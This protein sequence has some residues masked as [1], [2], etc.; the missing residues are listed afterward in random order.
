MIFDG[1]GEPGS[2]NERRFCACWGKV[3]PARDLL[4]DSAAAESASFLHLESSLHPFQSD[5]L[6]LQPLSAKP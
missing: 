2:P 1:V 5:T 4:S 6:T 3:Q